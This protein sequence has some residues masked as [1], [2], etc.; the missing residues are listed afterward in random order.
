MAGRYIYCFRG[1]LRSQLVQ[2]WLREA[3]VAYP[4]ISGGYKALRH[5]LLDTLEQ[6]AKLPMVLV[7]GTPAAVKPCWSTSWQRVSIWKAQ[8]AIAVHLLAERWWRR[9]RRLILRIVWLCYC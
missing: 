4:R 8:R 3:G 6:S 2:Q 5:F 7:G 9:A 1:G